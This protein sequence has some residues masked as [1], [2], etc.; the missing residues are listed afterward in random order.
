VRNS[1]STY[2]SQCDK[3]GKTLSSDQGY[4]PLRSI[5]LKDMRGSYSSGDC[6]RQF[7]DLCEDCFSGFNGL[8]QFLGAEKRWEELRQEAARY[9]S[10]HEG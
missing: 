10:I 3:C 9:R 1:T 6:H 5:Y 4:P 8:L 7:I 2:T